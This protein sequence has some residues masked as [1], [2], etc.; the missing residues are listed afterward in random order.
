MN[1]KAV[2]FTN[3]C[4]DWCTVDGSGNFVACNCENQPYLVLD[5]AGKDCNGKYI[6]HKKYICT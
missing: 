5:D 3:G 6:L 2:C 4:S 1:I